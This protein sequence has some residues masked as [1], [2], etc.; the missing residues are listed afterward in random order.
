[1]FLNE[2]QVFAGN[3]YLNKQDA[4]K[5]PNFSALENAEAI[6]QSKKLGLW[7]GN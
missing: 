5:C 7:S 2:E 3:A 1:V 4:G 6:A